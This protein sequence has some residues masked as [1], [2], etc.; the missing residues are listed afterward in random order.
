MLWKFI[1]F[2]NRDKANLDLFQIYKAKVRSVY[3]IEYA[4]ADKCGKLPTHLK[5]M[6]KTGIIILGKNKVFELSFFFVFTFVIV[7]V[8]ICIVFVFVS[9]C[10]LVSYL[11]V[12]VLCH[13]SCFVVC[14]S[15]C[16]CSCSFMYL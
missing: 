8:C 16:C 5:K 6:G 12:Y 14:G 13:M 7:F 2:S 3:K 15:F 9:V 4:I 10:V 11:H 1:L